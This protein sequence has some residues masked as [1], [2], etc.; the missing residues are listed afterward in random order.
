M[1]GSEVRLLR[2]V[3]AH[4]RRDDGTLAE[5]RSSVNDPMTDRIHVPRHRPHDAR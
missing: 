4:F 2:D 3:R 5:R 1:F